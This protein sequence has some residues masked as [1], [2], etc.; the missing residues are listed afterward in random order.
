[1]GQVIGLTTH[2]MH[3]VYIAND[4]MITILGIPMNGVESFSNDQD[5]TKQKLEDSGC[6]KRSVTDGGTTDTGYL[7]LMT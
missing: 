3:G 1:M 4:E 5:V 7:R 6:I 2:Y